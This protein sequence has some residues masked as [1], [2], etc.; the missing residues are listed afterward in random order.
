MNTERMKVLRRVSVIVV[1]LIAW[2]GLALLITFGVWPSRTSSHPRPV[3]AGN[4]TFMAPTPPSFIVAQFVAGEPVTVA[5]QGPNG[6]LVVVTQYPG[7]PLTIHLPEQ[8]F[9]IDP[10]GTRRQVSKSEFGHAQFEHAQLG[11]QSLGLYDFRHNPEI[12]LDDLK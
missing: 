12:N 5:T 6:S 8:Y 3:A 7:L 10:D 4:P 2:V 9:V 11:V 1:V